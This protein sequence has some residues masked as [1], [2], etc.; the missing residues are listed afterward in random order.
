MAP[1]TVDVWFVSVTRLA[2]RVPTLRSVLDATELDRI[3][4]HRHPGDRHRRIVGRGVLRLLLSTYLGEA[5][6][7][8]AIA[9]HC[10]HCGGSHG[11]LKVRG[12]ETS[13]AYDSDLVAYAFSSA[14]VG[15]DV[16][17]IRE[18]PWWFALADL[19]LPARERMA[20]H[21]LPSQHQASG[22]L[23][24]WTAREALGKAIGTGIAVSARELERRAAE[25]SCTWTM[26]ALRPAP[27]IAGAVAVAGA[28]V[29]IRLRGWYR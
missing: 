21:A 18:L 11:P 25:V 24:A 22:F 9:Q 12:I 5:P 14:P 27:G 1:G 17:A 19:V 29:D 6:E 28:G 7:D 15:V 23:A 3:G 13:L 16:E 4:R 2:S 26:R 8:I 10:R 20:I